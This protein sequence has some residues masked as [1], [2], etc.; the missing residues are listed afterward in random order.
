[1]AI[2]FISADLFVSKLHDFKLS[3]ILYV[4]MLILQIRVHIKF[5]FVDYAD[6]FNRFEMAFVFNNSQV[7]KLHKKFH[8]L[9]STSLAV[10]EI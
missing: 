5:E 10:I 9:L 7:L 6:L 3:E 8:K 1:M 4:Y 2:A